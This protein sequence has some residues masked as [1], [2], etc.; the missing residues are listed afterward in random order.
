[1]SSKIINGRFLLHRTTGVERYAKEILSEFD[2]IVTPGNY[3][4]AV[5][6]EVTDL[7]VFSNIK[8]V[9]V[10]SLNNRLWEHFSFPLYAIINRMIPVSLCNVAPILYPGIVCIHD[11]KPLVVPQ[12]LRKTFVLWYRLL[13]FNIFHRAKAIIT[14]SEFSKAEILKHSNFNSSKI[15]VIPSAWQHF[16]RINCAKDVL[17]K[18]ELETKSYYFTIS[19]LEPNKNLKWI[20]EVAQNNPEDTFVIAGALNTR[21]FADN[22]GNDLSALACSNI[23]IL[24]Y[25]TDEEAKA[26]MSD[27]KA[28]LFPTFYEGFG[29]PPLE[30]MSTGAVVIVSDSKVMHE[31]YEDSVYYINPKNYNINLRKLIE[32]NIGDAKRILNKY[33]FKK[34][35]FLLKSLLEDL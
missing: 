30:A 25:I 32:T 7:P 20:L 31:V 12:S 14:V 6:P 21:V 18:Y 28:F 3:I 34:S 26:L 1:M 22:S 29:L 33:S 11:I 9:K 24:G 4:I 8:V 16:V 2:K 13:F 5:P 35:A 23:R 17:R 15:Y 27:C 19:S 10:G